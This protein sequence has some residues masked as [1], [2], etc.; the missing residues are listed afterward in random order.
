MPGTP[1]YLKSACCSRESHSSNGLQVTGSAEKGPWREEGVALQGSVCSF[2]SLL[3]FPASQLSPEPLASSLH[4]LLLKVDNPGSLARINSS[5]NLQTGVGKKNNFPSTLLG[6]EVEIPPVI[7]DKLTREKHS[8]KTLHPSCMGLPSGSVV[9]NPPAM[10]EV[11]ETW[12]WSLHR[13]DLL[14]EGMANL[15]STLAWRI[16]WTEERG[17]LQSTGSQSRT[18]LT[19]AT[20]HTLD[21]LLYT[22]EI[23]RKTKQLPEMGQAI[24][25][26]TISN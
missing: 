11:Q 10:Q 1:L 17:G 19:E 6:S 16:P 8:C 7:K 9:E 14:E 13:E 12:V 22:S 4:L 3:S 2:L 24:I 15:S 5:W 20:E 21:S 18:Q 26:N 23:P 25:L